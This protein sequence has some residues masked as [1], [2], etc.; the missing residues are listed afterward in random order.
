MEGT[1]FMLIVIII[2]REIKIVWVEQRVNFSVGWGSGGLAF[3]F[4]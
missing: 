3:S 4:V 1:V 2:S